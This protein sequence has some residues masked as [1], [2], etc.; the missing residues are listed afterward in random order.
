LSLSDPNYRRL[1]TA[2]LLAASKNTVFGL[3]ENSRKLLI[4][5]FFVFC[6]SFRVFRQALDK[7]STY[8]SGDRQSLAAFIIRKRID[9]SK[10]EGS[11]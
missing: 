6:V 9:E 4:L 3:L 8:K 1:K 7:Y 11:A 2:A 5:T 10:I